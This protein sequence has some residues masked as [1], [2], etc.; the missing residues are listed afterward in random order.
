MPESELTVDSIIDQIAKKTGQ[1][2]TSSIQ[3]VDSDLDPFFIQLHHTGKVN[4]LPGF[5]IESFGES[6][7]NS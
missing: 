3:T 2:D 1:K 6:K 7:V 5:T 4:P